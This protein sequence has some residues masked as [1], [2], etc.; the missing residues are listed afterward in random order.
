MD[1][2]NE[3]IDI[4]EMYKY[5]ITELHNED[6]QKYLKYLTIYFSKEHKKDKYERMVMD[7]KYL[8]VEKSNPN[9]KIEL[10]PSKFLDIQV[11]YI[12]LKKYNNEILYK[13]NNL[14]ESKSNIT[15]DNRKEFEK[16]KKQF[17]LCKEKIGEIDLINN[18]YYDDIEKLLND[19]IDKTDL[20]IKFYKIRNEIYNNI[21]IHIKEELKSKMIKYFKENK[22]KI[23]GLPI[24]NKLGKEN[25]VPSI[26]IEKWFQWI[27]SVYK[28]IELQIDM[29]KIEEKMNKNEEEYNLNTRYMII[30][31][32]MIKE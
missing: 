15:E 27:E 28:Y 31:K 12:E 29:D 3:N 20:L 7:G 22:K 2:I 5:Q 9:K 10:T 11:L 16:L 25:N 17:I 8:L 21:K 19:K 26:E 30:K 24:I 4:K 14:I 23:P 18:E 13:I 6:Y 32:P 1:M